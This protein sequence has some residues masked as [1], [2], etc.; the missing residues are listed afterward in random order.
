MTLR[1]KISPG[2]FMI[3]KPGYDCDTPGL[4]DRFKIFD[5]DWNFSGYMLESGFGSWDTS[6]KD[7]STLGCLTNDSSPVTIP[8]KRTY[9]FRPAAIVVGYFNSEQPFNDITGYQAQGAYAF[10]AAGS[11]IFNNRIVLN[12]VPRGGAYYAFE[13]MRYVLY[14]VF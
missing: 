3:S 5:S 8:F 11:T 4:Q 1:F 13:T 6:D 2:R 12:R 10:A 9:S 7:K 14:G